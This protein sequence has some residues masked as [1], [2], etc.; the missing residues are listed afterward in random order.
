MQAWAGWEE[1]GHQGE[2]KLGLRVPRIGHSRM[3]GRRR[4]P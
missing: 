2:K 1:E 3:P 4:T